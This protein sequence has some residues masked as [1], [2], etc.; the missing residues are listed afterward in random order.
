MSFF[1]LIFIFV[2]FKFITFYYWI[3]KLFLFYSDDISLEGL[4][5]ELQECK[6]D[7]VSYF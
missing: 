1:N 6:D 3:T 7:D 5:Q 2:V 4:Q